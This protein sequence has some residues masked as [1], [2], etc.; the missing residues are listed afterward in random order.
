MTQTCLL[1]IQFQTLPPSIHH[2]WKEKIDIVFKITNG[3]TE[4][5]LSMKSSIKLKCG[6][7]NVGV[8]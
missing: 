7:R 3:I 8:P 6:I 4:D 2:K 5:H 1:L